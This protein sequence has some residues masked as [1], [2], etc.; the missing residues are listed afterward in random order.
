MKA[1]IHG[2]F[3]VLPVNVLFLSNGD[4][5]YCLSKFCLFLPLLFYFSYSEDFMFSISYLFHLSTTI[6]LADL[7]GNNI[8]HLLVLPW[9]LPC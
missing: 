8:G 1:T 2:V 7:E 3:G 9:F 4:T 6:L 5:D